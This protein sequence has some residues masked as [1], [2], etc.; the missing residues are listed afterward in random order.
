[1]ERQIGLY[2]TSREHPSVA[3]RVQFRYLDTQSHWRWGPAEGMRKDL[4]CECG[5]DEVVFVQAPNG[6][7]WAQC[8][9]CG[10]QWEV[11]LG[12]PAKQRTGSLLGWVLHELEAMNTR[13]MRL[14]VSFLDGVVEPV[15]VG[16]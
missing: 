16:T 15:G 11:L 14:V 7:V 8:A 9:V 12:D 10:G 2:L 13:E 1:M 5:E 6:D 4:R 3:Q